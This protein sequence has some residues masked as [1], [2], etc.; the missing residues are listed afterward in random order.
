MPTPEP[1]TL[2]PHSPALQSP[3]DLPGYLQEK[4]LSQDLRDLILSLPAEKGWVA[5]YLHQYQGFWHTTRQLLGVLACQKH[6]QAH[7]TDIVLV[8][9][10]KS[11]TTW[12]KAIMFALLNRSRFPDSKQHPLLTTNPHVLVPFMEHEYIDTQF[13]DFSRN[14]KDSFVSLWHFT[15]RLK[16]PKETGENSLDETFDKFC[17]G[18]SLYGPFWDHVLGYWKVSLENPEKVLFLKYE[19]CKKEPKVLLRRLSEFLGCPFSQEEE[20][21]GVIGEILK[22]CS[23]ENLSNLEVNR[24]GKLPSGE[25]NC[26]FFRRGEVGDS[27]NHLTAEMLEKM[28]QITEQKF[29][30]WG[31]NLS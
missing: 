28:D 19:D 30:R 13:P 18:V 3:T 15:N 8:T 23:F 27:V 20:T 21:C 24:T 25:E 1:T 29:K 9:T 12:L 4:E 17:R 5:S 22:L 14:P 16:E 6:F 11:G 26:T 7:D 31:L 10:P 2:L